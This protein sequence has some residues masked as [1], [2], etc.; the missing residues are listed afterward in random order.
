MIKWPER[1]IGAIRKLF[2]PLQDIDVYVEDTN[3]E[4][5]YRALLKAATNEEIRVERV[6]A[7]NGR[8]NVIDAAR[9]YNQKTRPALFI[10]DGDLSW[11]KGESAPKI[12]GL[13]CHDAYCVEN[14]IFCEKALILILSQEAVIT[15][16][17]AKSLLAYSDWMESIQVPLIEL[18]AAFATADLAVP[19]VPTVSQGVHQ[20]CVDKK[21]DITKVSLAKDVALNAAA[22]TVG[23]EITL[24]TYQ[25]ILNRLKNLPC[26]LYAVSGKDFLI[27]LIEYHLKMLG[28][29]IKRKSLR[30][31]LVS[32]G[33]MDRFKPLANILRHA[34]SGYL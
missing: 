3:D 15:E 34:A 10:I 24:E 29:Q 23:S 4:A 27:P 25:H 30:I 12:V 21:I 1:A 11:V 26:P 14:L 8:N 17:E 32:I 13:H 2:E 33:D 22:D 31:R 20:M 6:F 19:K 28:Y 7:L 16:A 5:F 9:G 18:F